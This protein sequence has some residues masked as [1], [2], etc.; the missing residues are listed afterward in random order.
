[1]SRPFKQRQ[2]HRMNLL[3]LREKAE[4]QL[5]CEKLIISRH[6][7]EAFEAFLKEEQPAFAYKTGQALLDT[8]PEEVLERLICNPAS[9]DYEEVGE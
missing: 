3:I 2:G 9:N 4:A 1:M 5:K 6:G 8:T 7:K